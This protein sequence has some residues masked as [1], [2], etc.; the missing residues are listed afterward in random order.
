[1]SGSPHSNPRINI[2][3]LPAAIIQSFDDRRDIIFGQI[4][5]AGTAVSDALNFNMHLATEDELKTLF[6][7][8]DLFHRILQ[9]RSGVSITGGGIVPILDVIGVDEAGGATDAENTITF[10]G[11]ATADGEWVISIVDEKLFTITIPVSSGDADTVVAAAVDAAIGNLADPPFTS[12]VVANVVTLTAKDGGTLG[13]N[14]G[15]RIND[16]QFGQTVAIS[17]WSGGAVDPV[18]TGTLDAIEGRRYTGAQWP[19]T[20]VTTSIADEFANRFNT[21]NDILDG[22]IFQ[23]ANDTFANATALVAPFN[24][25][26]LVFMGNNVVA[27][28][29]D[30]GPAILQPADY[31]ASFFMAVR[32]KRLTTGALI[33][34]LITA[35]NAPLDATGGPHT[36]SLPY[37]NTPMNDVPVTLTQNLFNLTEQISLEDDG[38]TT[39]GVNSAG[40]QMIMGAVVTT[41]TTDA[42]SNVND[43]FRFLNFVDTGSVCREIFFR[44]LKS[45]F[46]QSRLTEGNIVEGLSMTNEQSIKGELLGIYR[47]LSN[48]ALTQ[49]GPEAEEFFSDNTIVVVDLA[50]RL[51]TISG[52]LPIVTQLGTINYNLSLSF[53]IGQ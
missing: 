46:S 53:T 31:A 36:A 50:N 45:V 30:D 49:A 17:G 48:L 19:E 23:G 47:D 11:P 21:P 20:W 42:S 39:Y 15:I 32:D 18:I 8:G 37:F 16:G 12:I 38:F 40:N 34:D 41:R 24:N 52:P 6:G 5:G 4:E 14:Y 27:E 1:M 2:Q 28:T 33:A 3:L 22:V 13:N 25:Q 43:S 9:W 10:A 7:T 44:T 29:L 35:L 26:S 51:A